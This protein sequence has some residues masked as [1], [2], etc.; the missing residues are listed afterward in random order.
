MNL[1]TAISAGAEALTA[2]PGIPTQRT[3]DAYTAYAS[4]HQLGIAL[5]RAHADSGA[6]LRPTA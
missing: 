2:S 6:D 3:S 1:S 5:Q 4:V